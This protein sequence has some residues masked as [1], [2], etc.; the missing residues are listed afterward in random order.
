MMTTQQYFL[1]TTEQLH[2]RTQSSCDSELRI[3]PMANLLNP[4]LERERAPELP[5][6]TEE[7]LSV[8]G[9]LQSKWFS[10]GPQ[11]SP[12]LGLTRGTLL[13]WFAFGIVVLKLQLTSE[14]LMS[15]SVVKQPAVKIQIIGTYTTLRV[16][17]VVRLDRS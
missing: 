4:N 1:D 9:R 8:V 15:N 13:G 6:L 5:P 2:K 12:K 14:D 11:T 10:P 17:D 3:H 16:V 7:L